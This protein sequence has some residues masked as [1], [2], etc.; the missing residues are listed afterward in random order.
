[1]PPDSE[2]RDD[3]WNLTAGNCC[4]ISASVPSRFDVRSSRLGRVTEPC[5]TIAFSSWTHS[6]SVRT[7]ACKCSRSAFHCTRSARCSSSMRL[8][9]G[10]GHGDAGRRE[11]RSESPPSLAHSPRLSTASSNWTCM[12]RLGKELVLRALGAAL[13]RRCSTLVFLPGTCSDSVFVSASSWSPLRFFLGLRFGLPSWDL[14][15]KPP[16]ATGSNLP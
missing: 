8:R 1:M 13:L 16:A 14:L 7:W 15:T 3:Y 4:T 11:R 6:A 2:R 9:R 10:A 5:W 12:R